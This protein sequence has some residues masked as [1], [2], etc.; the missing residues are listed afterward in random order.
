MGA[1]VVGGARCLCG[2]I[3]LSACFEQRENALD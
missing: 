2:L 1:A 3:V